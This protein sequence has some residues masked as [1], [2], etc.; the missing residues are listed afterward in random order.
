MAMRRF[1]VF[2][3]RPEQSAPTT[4]C[5]DHVRVRVAG[6]DDQILVPTVSED[7]VTTPARS[8]G[9]ERTGEEHQPCNSYFH[10]G[11]CSRLGLRSIAR[12][13]IGISLYLSVIGPVPNGFAFGYLL[14]LK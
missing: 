1:I 10:N 13:G 4:R 7:L 8:Q 12:C 3:S 5:P 9:G 11:F 2:T 6:S 14:F